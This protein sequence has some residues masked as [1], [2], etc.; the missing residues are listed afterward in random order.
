MGGGR[1]SGE[2]SGGEPRR[3][4]RSLPPLTHKPRSPVIAA[5]PLDH[6]LASGRFIGSPPPTALRAHES[7]RDDNGNAV[8]SG[9][10]GSEAS[11]EAGEE[12]RCV[13]KPA[14]PALEASQPRITLNTAPRCASPPPAHAIVAVENAT[15]VAGSGAP[16]TLRTV[17]ATASDAA[18][19]RQAL[20]PPPKLV[21]YRAEGGAEAVQEWVPDEG[22]QGLATPPRKG[23]CPSI[24][25]LPSPVMGR[26]SLNRPPPPAT[27]RR[28]RS[29]V[30]L[31]PISK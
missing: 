14:N 2:V 23:S 17:A 29:T 11:S 13:Y 8:A 26:H 20:T 27:T 24:R 6:D 25:D 12:E 15:S 31:T 22:G 3:K 4:P 30:K 10:R 21:T 16:L 18:S 19:I 7:T 1:T 5:S 28:T 9:R